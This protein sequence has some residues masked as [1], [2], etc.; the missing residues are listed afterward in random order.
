[1]QMRLFSI[2]KFPLKANSFKMFKKP[3][4]GFSSQQSQPTV[5]AQTNPPK[6]TWFQ[7]FFGPQTY[8]ASPK[9]KKR[10]LILIPCFLNNLC[11]GSPYAWSIVAG[12]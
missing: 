7:K 6:Q 8:I 10:W 4:F 2:K 11:F 3:S 12:L 5:E 1:M 9:F